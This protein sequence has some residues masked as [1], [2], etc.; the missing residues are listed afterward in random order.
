MQTPAVS[1][2]QAA[3][4][5]LGAVAL[6]L[7]VLAILLQFVI[8][9]IVLGEITLSKRLRYAVRGT[10]GVAVLALAIAAAVAGQFLINQMFPTQIG[11]SLLFLLIGIAAIAVLVLILLVTVSSDTGSSRTGGQQ[12]GLR[13]SIITGVDETAAKISSWYRRYRATR[14]VMRIKEHE[15]SLRQQRSTED[16]TSPG[17]D[18]DEEDTG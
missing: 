18:A 4:E 15:I 8:P 7:P 3:F 2:S 5:I 13:Q 1:D 6:T 11:R 12:G 9:R 14:R 10:A 17:A 16:Y